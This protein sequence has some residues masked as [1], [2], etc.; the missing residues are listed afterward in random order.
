[1]PIFEAAF[2]V[3]SA[4]PGAGED[5]VDAK[6]MCDGG[7]AGLG[8]A[9]LM[10]VEAF[11]EVGGG[12]EV[13]L[14]GVVGVDRAF[15]VEEVDGGHYS[16]QMILMAYAPMTVI[17]VGTPQR[18]TRTR[19]RMPKKFQ[20]GLSSMGVFGFGGGGCFGAGGLWAVGNMVEFL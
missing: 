20:S 13:V 4:A 11:F 18:V 5:H 10:L 9:G 3:A 1:M 15:E 6:I 17:R 7:E 14:G 2:Q 16:P 19:T 12:A 8:L